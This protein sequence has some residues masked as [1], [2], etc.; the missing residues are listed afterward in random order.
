MTT[1]ADPSPLGVPAWRQRRPWVKPGSPPTDRE[2][3]ILE[4]VSHGYSNGEIAKELYVTENSVKTL[5]RSL[6][7]RLGARDR[8]HAVRLGF[9]LGIL[10]GAKSWWS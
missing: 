10:R 4:L 2:Q 5:L 7:V 3:Q 9:E 1:I 8:A 6:Y